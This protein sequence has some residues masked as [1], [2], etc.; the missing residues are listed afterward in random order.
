MERRQV[1]GDRLELHIEATGRGR[2]MVARLP[3]GTVLATGR[4]Y[5]HLRENIDKAV[6]ALYGAEMKVAL[7]VGSSRRAPPLEPGTPEPTPLPPGPAALP[8]AP[9]PDRP[10]GL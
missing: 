5:S 4:H 8:A 7:M 6:R 3:D 1:D 2:R 9:D 10:P